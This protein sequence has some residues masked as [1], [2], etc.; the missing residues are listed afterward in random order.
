MNLRK[1]KTQ[2]QNYWNRYI[3]KERDIEK[4]FHIDEIFRHGKRRERLGR[5]VV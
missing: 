3:E 5:A 4:Q 1:A 2:Y